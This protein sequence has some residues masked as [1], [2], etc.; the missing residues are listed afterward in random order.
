MI[1]GVFGNDGAFASADHEV[2]GFELAKA[3]LIADLHVLEVVAVDRFSVE[4]ALGNAR[5]RL[6]IVRIAALGEVEDAADT[7]LPRFVLGRKTFGG[8]VTVFG[9]H[10]AGK[11]IDVVPEITEFFVVE[12]EDAA[13]ADVFEIAKTEV[14]DPEVRV[15]AERIAQLIAHSL[16]HVVEGFERDGFLENAV[17]VEISVGVFF[18][19]VS[20]A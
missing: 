19:F 7:N 4:L 20:F 17:L 13:H 1:A 11:E 14:G 2:R 15:G 8:D 5:E 3:V 10:L 9:N 18:H 16:K 12:E 6:R